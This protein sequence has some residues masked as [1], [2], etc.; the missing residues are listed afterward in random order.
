M[1]SERVWRVLADCRGLTL[2]ELVVVVTVAGILAALSIPALWTYLRSATLRA[3]AEE[4]VTVL[5]S[6]RQ[7][8]IRLNTTVC[9]TNNGAAVQYHVGSCATAAWTG[10]GTDGAG[11]IRLANGLT[12]SGTNNLCFNHIGAGSA[13]PAPCANNG[14]LTITNPGGGTLNV[15]MATTGRLRIQ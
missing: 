15:V 1:V 6:A 2:S 14:T 13:T 4:A 12:V 3:A 11:N 5:N 10:P 7:L 8:A 9:V